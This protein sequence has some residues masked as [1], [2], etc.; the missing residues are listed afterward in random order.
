MFHHGAASVVLSPGVQL[1]ARVGDII[2]YVP[3]EAWSVCGGPIQAHYSVDIVELGGSNSVIEVRVG[4]YRVVGFRK[5]ASP[6]PWGHAADALLNY[7]NQYAQKALL[8]WSLVT[9]RTEYIAPYRTVDELL[10]MK[11]GRGVLNFL[12]R[13]EKAYSEDSDR[14]ARRPVVREAVRR[15]L[16]RRERVRG[17]GVAQAARGDFG[18][19]RYLRF[20]S[21]AQLDEDEQTAHRIWQ[22]INELVPANYYVSASKHYGSHVNRVHLAATPAHYKADGGT[23]FSRGDNKRHSRFDFSVGTRWLTEVYEQ[24]L[25][26]VDGR[27]C[28]GAM[29]LPDLAPG[30]PSWKVRLATQRGKCFKLFTSYAFV[31]RLSWGQL[32]VA[33]GQVSLLDKYRKLLK[34]PRG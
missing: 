27:I 1:Q 19:K 12:I 16:A 11:T 29:R 3:E 26:L 13:T 31:C 15:L 33:A 6:D 8:H 5:D 20:E 7:L 34:L 25:A 10:A 28:L 22:H 4:G 30:I 2:D 18:S 14:L 9:H 24:G 21:E 23:F 17:R 32:L